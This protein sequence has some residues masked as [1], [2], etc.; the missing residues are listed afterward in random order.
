MDRIKKFIRN[1]KTD[2][3]F[4]AGVIVAS[5]AVSIVYHNAIRNAVAGE[6]W[7]GILAF[8]DTKTNDLVL[9][10]N[11]INKTSETLT[12]PLKEG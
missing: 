9:V 7:E 5:A 11:K 1:N 6:K 12:I 8:T 2:L 3:A 4:C 10:V